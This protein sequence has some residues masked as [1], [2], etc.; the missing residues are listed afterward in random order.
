M[1]CVVDAVVLHVNVALAY[2]YKL[3][4]GTDLVATA[5]ALLCLYV[6][7]KLGALFHVLTLGWLAVV[8]F[9]T[10]PK[11]YQEKQ[12]EI[13]ALLAEAKTQ[14]ETYKAVIEKEVLSKIPKASAAPSVTEKK[15]E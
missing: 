1:R 15:D 12:T 10:V 13:D 9:F 5:Q 8:A 11:V 3:G 14:I 4:T 6:V 2:G 7:S